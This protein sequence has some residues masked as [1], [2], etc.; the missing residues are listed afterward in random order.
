MSENGPEGES[1]EET[2]RAIAQELGR[3]LESSIDSFD[4]DKIA[5]SFGVDPTVARD[6]VDN[7]SGWLRGFADG[8]GAEVSRRVGEPRRPVSDADLFGGA[9]PH[10]LDVPTEEQALALAALD[11][12][13]WT[14][15]PGSDSLTAKGDGPG[16]SDALGIVRELRVRDWIAGDG[17]LTLVGRSALSR[18]LAAASRGQ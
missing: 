4:S 15:E 7:T 2:L 13:R 17:E 6:W 5:E 3:K 10:P 1:F 8:L 11:S 16:P 9:V 18:W 12:G 14:V